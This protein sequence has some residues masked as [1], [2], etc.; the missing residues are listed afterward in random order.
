LDGL[1]RQKKEL[2]K[3]G[4]EA[5]DFRQQAKSVAAT[6]KQDASRYI[7]LRLAAHFLRRRNSGDTKII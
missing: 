7:R 3:T 4:D 1:N 2:E 6:M 5:A